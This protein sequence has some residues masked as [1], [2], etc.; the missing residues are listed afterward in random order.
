[1]GRRRLM[2]R[3]LNK[4]MNRWINGDQLIARHVAITTDCLL[5]R[6]QTTRPLR[7]QTTTN[8]EST[9]VSGY[10]RLRLANMGYVG[11]KTIIPIIKE[12]LTPCYYTRKF[13]SILTVNVTVARAHT[14]LSIQL[15]TY[16]IIAESLMSNGFVIIVNENKG[17]SIF[18]N[19]S[20]GY[21]WTI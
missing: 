17:F 16:T 21:Q 19:T 18:E 11:G 7:N 15:Y 8:V 9:R 4:Q 13:N 6:G 20:T 1:M 5:K 10:Q 12:F 2:H 14:L 3:C